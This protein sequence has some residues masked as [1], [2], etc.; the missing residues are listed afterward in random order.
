MQEELN[1]K[2]IHEI[3]SYLAEHYASGDSYAF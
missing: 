1:T 3:L 2:V